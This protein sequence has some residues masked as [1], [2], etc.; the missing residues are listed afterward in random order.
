[1][2]AA[3]SSQQSPPAAQTTFQH[4]GRLEALRFLLGGVEEGRPPP[5]PGQEGV[6]RVLRVNSH[7][8]GGRQVPEIAQRQAE[9]PNTASKKL[10]K[11]PAAS[12][13][14]NT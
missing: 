9:T 8:L 12:L 10:W 3:A 4:R 11:P 14:S 2:P 6:H 7:M 1:M 5:C 13:A